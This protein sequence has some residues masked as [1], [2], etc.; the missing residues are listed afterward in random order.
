MISQEELQHCFRS[1]EEVAD[2]GHVGRDAYLIFLEDISGRSLLVDEFDD[3]PISLIVIFYAA[4]CS[5]SRGCQND[6]PSISL[7]EV[8]V[9]SGLL[10]VFCSSVKGTT[11]S[12]I[13]DPAKPSSSRSLTFIVFYR[14]GRSAN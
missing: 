2:G 13:V 12:V 1:L 11:L 9:S 6:N 10:T 3:L 4:A 5:G 14:C 8:D 7:E